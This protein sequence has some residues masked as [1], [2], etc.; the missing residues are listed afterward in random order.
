MTMPLEGVRILDFSQALAGP[1]AMRTLG[2]LGA[3]VIK[4]EQPGVGDLSRRLGPHFLGGESAYFMNV[5]RNKR[6]I[7]L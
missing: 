7:T 1:F 6:G 5:N 3:D 4:V 2:D